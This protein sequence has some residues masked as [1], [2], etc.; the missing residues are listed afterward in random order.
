MWHVRNDELV[1]LVFDELPGEV[2]DDCRQHLRTCAS[3][4]AAFE[5]LSRAVALLEKEPTEPAPPFA[6]ARLKARIERRDSKS[7]WREPAWTPLVL[8]NAAGILLVLFLIFFAG[9]WLEGSTLWQ[10]VKTWPLA[11]AFGPRSLIAVI[12]FSAGALITLALTPIFWW[13]SKRPPKGLVK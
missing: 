8:G 5:E 9:G 10:A 6:W 4:S 11:G 7:D 2:L 12:F 13:E 1:G 3:C